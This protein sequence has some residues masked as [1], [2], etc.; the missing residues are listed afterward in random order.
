MQLN[1]INQNE[2][3]TNEKQELDRKIQQYKSEIA[4]LR[5]ENKEFLN[6]ISLLAENVEPC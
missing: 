2:N 4:K 3:D 6:K 5:K 1:K